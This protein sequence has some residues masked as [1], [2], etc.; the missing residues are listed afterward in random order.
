MM[1]HRGTH[2]PILDFRYHSKQRADYPASQWLLMGTYQHRL[3]YPKP[4]VAKD[5]FGYCNLHILGRH[6]HHHNTQCV[7]RHLSRWR[8]MYHSQFLPSFQNQ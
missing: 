2:T 8:L 1:N 3:S 6:S 7:S 5:S 4:W